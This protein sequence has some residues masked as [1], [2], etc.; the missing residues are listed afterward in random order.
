M[1]LLLSSFRP[2]PGAPTS[3]IGLTNPGRGYSLATSSYVGIISRSKSSF[4]LMSYM[5]FLTFGMD[6]HGRR[7]VAFVVGEHGVLGPQSELVADGLQSAG[8]P[9]KTIEGSIIINRQQLF[10]YG[11]FS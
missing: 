3:T 10:S 7:A 8:L 2:T 6:L 1:S 5:I 11:F 4:S 9:I